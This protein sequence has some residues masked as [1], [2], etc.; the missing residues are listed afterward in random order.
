MRV[1]VTGASGF[2]GSALTQALLG[3]GDEVVGLTRRPKEPRPGLRWVSRVT[4]EELEGCGAVVNLAGETIAARWTASRK[5]AIVGSRVDAT[6]ELVRA[7]AQAKQRPAVFVSASAVGF[8]GTD[9]ERVFDESSASGSGFL[10]GVARAW[11]EAARPAQELTRLVIVRLGVVV[12]P[13]GGALA[14]MLPAFRAGLGGVI[15]NGRQ[16]LSFVSLHDAV[17]LLLFALDTPS[18]RGVVNA[19]APAPVRQADFA[20]A[21]GAALGRPT[22]LPTPTFGLELLYGRELTRETL[23]AG[24]QVRGRA[25]ELGFVY[26]DPTLEAALGRALEVPRSIGS[27]S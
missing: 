23:L 5:R 27:L 7:L 22:I 15:G 20:H 24:Q 16:W 3:R 14:A 13:G 21:L 1:L 8:Y 17:R 2:I 19:V 26:E 10:A 6:A 18:V 12:G 4:P 9:P 25:G 11:E